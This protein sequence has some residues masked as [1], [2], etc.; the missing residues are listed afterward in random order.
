MG[1]P[2]TEPLPVRYD[3]TLAVPCARTSLRRDCLCKPVGPIR[4]GLYG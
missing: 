1:R 2:E 3:S 4:S